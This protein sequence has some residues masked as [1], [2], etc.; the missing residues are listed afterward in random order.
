VQPPSILS[1]PTRKLWLRPDRRQ[2]IKPRPTDDEKEAPPSLSR[3]D[4]DEGPRKADPPEAAESDSLV[5]VLA[6]VLGVVG[7]GEP[8]DPRATTG[9][10]AGN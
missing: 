4:G 6:A 1:A 8:L 5:A 9:Y 3:A 7:S 2:Q 10:R